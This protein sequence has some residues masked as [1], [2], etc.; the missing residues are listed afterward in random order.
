MPVSPSPPCCGCARVAALGFLPDFL[1]VG[2]GRPH[3]QSSERHSFWFGAPPSPNCPDGICGAE[4]CP[5]EVQRREIPCPLLALKQ[6]S[7][8]TVSLTA[9]C[10]SCG[11]RS[12]HHVTLAHF[13][14]WISLA[15]GDESVPFSHTAVLQELLDSVC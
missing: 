9:L 1:C 13:L 11:V 12:D 14:G 5:A 3:M 10:C 2:A 15:S 8:T 4:L 6:F 7:G